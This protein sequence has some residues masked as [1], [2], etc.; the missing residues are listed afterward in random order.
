MDVVEALIDEQ[1]GGE[2][3]DKVDVDGGDDTCGVDGSEDVATE[4]GH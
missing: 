2:L 4:V 3:M 1:V